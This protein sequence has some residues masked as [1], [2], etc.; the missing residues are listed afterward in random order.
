METKRDESCE[1]EHEFS[2]SEDSLIAWIFLSCHLFDYNK[3]FSIFSSLSPQVLF[4]R[5]LEI[6]SRPDLIERVNKESSFDI[7]SYRPVPFSKLE[8][9]SFVRLINNNKR[10]ESDIFLRRF[11]SLFHP[12]RTVN[13]LNSYFERLRQKEQNLFDFQY[14]LFKDLQESICKEVKSEK[15]INYVLDENSYEVFRCLFEKEKNE[16]EHNRGH[17]RSFSLD[18]IKS[19]VVGRWN[20]KI[21]CSLVG[22]GEVR[23]VSQSKSIIGRAS[24]KCHP[25]IDLSDLNLQSISRHH[26]ILS[27]RSDL[28]FYLECSGSSV[29]VNG[30]VFKKGSI[31]QLKDCDFLDIGGALFMFLENPE[32]IPS[33]RLASK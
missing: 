5:F 12:T 13:S 11:G 30:V 8:V 14:S 26:C 24:P 4:L 21:L 2:P 17:A 7:L 27:F 29:L 19:R 22:S 18:D 31:I 1:I 15:D 23:L 9:F 10:C 16:L 6:L 25:T 33:L 32:L 20:S 3:C 28:K